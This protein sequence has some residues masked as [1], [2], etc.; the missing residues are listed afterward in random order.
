[1][2]FIIKDWADNLMP[3]GEFDS[4]DDAEEYLCILLDESY[5]TDRQEYYIQI[6]EG[7]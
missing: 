3:Y 6:K 1:M 2:N 7:K 4:F 5:E